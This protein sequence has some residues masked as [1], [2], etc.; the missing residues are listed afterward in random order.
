MAAGC[1]SNMVPKHAVNV[2]SDSDPPAGIAS[3]YRPYI[4]S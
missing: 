2:N 3:S 4:C 1:T